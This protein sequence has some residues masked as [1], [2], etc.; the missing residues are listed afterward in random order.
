M[1]I[2]EKM[3][4]FEILPEEYAVLF[5]TVFQYGTAILFPSNL[6]N[7]QHYRNVNKMCSVIFGT[8][9]TICSRLFF[10]SA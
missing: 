5:L 10:S 6:L 1:L 7:R 4:D 2:D 8:P 9:D 3:S